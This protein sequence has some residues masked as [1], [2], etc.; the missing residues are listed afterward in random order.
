MDV[1]V[2][3]AGVVGLTAAV[4]LAE[5]GHAVQLVERERPGCRAS[6]VAAGLLTPS[7]PW[8]YPSALIELCHASEA[9]YPDFAQEL[10]QHTGIDCEYDLLGMLYPE[11]VG[12]PAEAVSEHSD[13]RNGLGF[14]VQRL[15]RGAL[16]RLQPGLGPGVLGV[17]WQPGS[18]R[19]RPPRLL[20]ALVRRA[21]QLDV[22]ILSDCPVERLLLH[23]GRVIGVRA[24]GRDLHA[25]AVVLAAGAWSGLLGESAGLNLA[26]APVRGQILLLSG[27]PGL[28]APVINDGDCYL[29]PRRDG[30]LLVGSTM[31]DAGFDATTTDAALSRLRR[32][33][34]VL[35]P[36]SAELPVET[37]WAGLR[38]GTVDR[39][40]YLG[41]VSEVPGLVLA[42][43]HFRNG[44]LLAPI[45]AELVCDVLAGRRSRIDLAPYRHRQVDPEARVLSA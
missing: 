35:L 2:V 31:E 26:V 7:T 37:S 28:L 42:T 6:W 43:G 23:Q 39:M 12:F 40:P 10:L 15:D 27:P 9:L 45:T 1:L 13:L 19:V 21:G 36:A 5:Q 18:A 38:P 25:D 14:A 29:V 30:R 8:R 33:A 32:L 4:R 11:G 3:G 22:S 44:I 41:A 34:S 17:A 24:R 16:D 20:A